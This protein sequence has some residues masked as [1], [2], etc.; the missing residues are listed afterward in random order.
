MTLVQSSIKFQKGLAYLCQTVGKAGAR[1]VNGHAALTETGSSNSLYERY[2]HRD[3]VGKYPS[4]SGAI[5]RLGR[6]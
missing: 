3:E 4:V 1:R 2:L 6:K 5:R